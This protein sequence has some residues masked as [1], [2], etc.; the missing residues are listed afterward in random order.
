MCWETKEPWHTLFMRPRGTCLSQAIDDIAI[1]DGVAKAMIWFIIYIW[2]QLQLVVAL[3]ATHSMT[4]TLTDLCSCRVDQVNRTTNGDDWFLMRT[5]FNLFDRSVISS[6]QVSLTMCF[7][8]SSYIIYTHLISASTC[9][10]IAPVQ[11]LTWLDYWNHGSHHALATLA[12]LALL[13][14]STAPSAPRWACFLH[15]K[16]P[17]FCTPLF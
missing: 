1:T 4:I 10:C 11:T 3:H 17:K 14:F 6:M 8:S 13:F 7:L 5:S 9:N 16:Q 12:Q 15:R 2:L